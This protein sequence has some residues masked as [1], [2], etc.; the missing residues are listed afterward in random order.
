MKINISNIIL[1]AVLV[2]FSGCTTDFEEM[3]TDKNRVSAETYLPVYNLTRAQLEFAGNNDFSYDTWRVNIIYASMITQQLTSST[4]YNG[5]KYIQNDDFA[6]A[7]FD[8]GYNDQV[9]YIVDLL[10]ITRDKPLYANL[11]QIGRIMKVMIFHR[12]TDVY[13]DVPYSEAGLAYHESNYAPAYD[14]QEFIYD[15]MLNEL[16]EAAQALDPNGDLPGSGDLIY[17]ESADPIGQWKKLAYSLMLR[18]GMRLSEV[19]EADAKVWV[20]RAFAGGVFT[21]NDDNAFILHDAAGGRPTVNRVSNILSGEFNSVGSGDVFLSKTFV[22]FMADNNDPRLGLY[23]EVQAT[24]DNT[25]ANQIG[26]PNDLDELGGAN[27]LSTDPNYPG[28]KGNYSTVRA[29]IFL[30]LEGPTFFVS[31]AQVELLLA[32]AAQR[33]WSVGGNAESHY[34]AGVTA[35]MEFL[36]QYNPAATISSADI[37]TY[38]TDNPYV[39]AN[40]IEMISEQYWV[41]SFLDWYE[42]WAN[43]R[44]TDFPTLVPVDYPG[45]ATN[46]QIPRRMLYPSHEASNNGDNLNEAIARQGSNTLMT[47]VWWDAE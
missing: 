43:W 7:L 39:S 40:G 36:T 32:E 12:M 42:V 37:A 3:N 22:D 47:R 46:A 11:H 1:T 25:P 41:A 5:G 21:S 45:N 16:N 10:E 4:W 2:I 24:G 20:E 19:N 18:L 15:D 13:G 28:A 30:T 38:L 23:A 14:P 27:D 6:S 35:A 26:M 31:Y 44:R 8:V 33:G 34:N 17:G 29:D 9:K